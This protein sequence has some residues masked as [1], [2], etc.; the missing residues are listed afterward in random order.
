MNWELYFINKVIK[1]GLDL[2]DG[3]ETTLVFDLTDL[4]NSYITK[5]II[6]LKKLTKSVG[7]FP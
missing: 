1:I 5:P 2:S 3:L 6:K 7:T 4:E